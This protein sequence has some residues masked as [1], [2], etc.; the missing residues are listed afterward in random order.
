MQVLLIGR[1]RSKMRFTGSKNIK[2]AETPNVLNNNPLVF[3][4]KPRDTTFN[5]NTSAK[6]SL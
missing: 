6:N 4:S 5:G 1:A 2:M 3:A